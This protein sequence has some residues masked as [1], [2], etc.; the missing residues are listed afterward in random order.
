MR[1]A[2]VG[3]TRFVGP[4]AVGQ[5][6]AAGHEVCLAHTGAHEGL[7]EV[8]HLHGERAELLGEGGAVERWRPD[9][10][11]DTF[12]GGATAWKAEQVAGC[13]ARCGAGQVVA[14]SSMDVYRYLIDAGIGE[15]NPGTPVPRGRLPIREDAPLRDAPYPGAA[16]VAGGG[17]HDNVAMEAALAAGFDGRVTALRPGTIYGPHRDSRERLIVEWVREGRRVVELPDGGDQLFHRVAVDRLG[18]AVAAALDHA[19]D[20]FWAC[21]VGDP[22][23]WTFAGLVGEIGRLLDWEFEFA[24]VGF[25]EADHPW[26][27]RHPVLCDTRR[28]EDVL[29]VSEPDP[30]AAL[31]ECV[32]W[33][34]ENPQADLAPGL[35]PAEKS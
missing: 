27:S 3:G 8:E 23:D 30:G 6:L 1:I 17:V 5:L 28:L 19:P 33:L 25:D 29:G 15:D 12:A 20:G 14:I 2:F 16:D 26:K 35:R 32:A 9:A 13:A 24:S 34:W 18:R 7:P 11:I 10:L 21:N 4:A 22:G 31:A